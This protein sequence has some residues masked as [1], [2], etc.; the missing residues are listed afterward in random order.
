MKKVLVILLTLVLVLSLAS[1]GQ[2]AEIKPVTLNIGML[3]GPT[4]M[5]MAKMLEEG[6]VMDK[7]IETN[8][9]IAAAPDELT[10]KVIS[11]EVQI[12]AVPTNMAA[13]YRY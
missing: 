1:C 13:Y 5:G 4:G 7:N 3:K 2:S 11:G 8:V 9:L 6:Y 12:A 10:A